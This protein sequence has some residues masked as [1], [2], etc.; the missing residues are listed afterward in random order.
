MRLA[1]EGFHVVINHLNTASDADRVAGEI[2]RA[3]GSASVYGFD[4]S[5]EDQVRLAAADIESQLGPVAVLVN[6]AGILRD[7]SFRKMSAVEW[8]EVIGVNLTGV[9]NTCSA[10]VPGM[11]ERK[12]GRIVNISSFVA[13]AGNFGQTNYA[14]AKAGMIGF[15]RSLAIETASHGVTVNCICPGFIETDMWRSIPEDVRSK[16]LDRIPMRRVGDPADIAAAVSYL[17]RDG[18]YVTGQTIN[19]N[20]G[21]FIG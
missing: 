11:M 19:V 14:A 8:S 13:Q 9:M 17:V 6:N 15:S 7:R 16:I 1:S 20:G 3:G 2:R 5:A 12:S 18:G 21:I 10:F 4:V